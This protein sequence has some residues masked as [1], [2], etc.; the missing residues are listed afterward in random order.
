[1]I[2]VCPAAGIFL[3]CRHFP[4]PAAPVVGVTELRT[5]EQGLLGSTGVCVLIVLL[6]QCFKLTLGTVKKPELR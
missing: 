1:M 6:W 2:L 5:H 4:C 3:P